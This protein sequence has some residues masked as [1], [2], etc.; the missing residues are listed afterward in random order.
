MP[1]LS[2]VKEISCHTG[3]A[4]GYG[5]VLQT[6]TNSQGM[7][8]LHVVQ[9]KQRNFDTGIITQISKLRSIFAS[10]QLPDD[11]QIIFH[12]S[13]IITTFFPKHSQARIHY[14]RNGPSHQ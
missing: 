1:I 9:K 10:S 11:V 5:F 3:L 7:V 2:L 13:Q 6:C 8:P 14:G 4:K 12:V